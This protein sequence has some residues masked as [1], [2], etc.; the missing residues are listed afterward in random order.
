M[1]VHVLSCFS[2]C[3]T[4]CD[5]MDCSPLG[6]S[7][8]DP[9]TT[10]QETGVGC[11]FDLQGI[12]PTHEPNPGIKPMSLASPAWAGRFFTTS[13]T[14]EAPYTHCCRRHCC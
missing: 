3:L 11:H 12:F 1:C 9:F 10:K 14:R 8:W 7:P 4:L 13:A 5:P 6:S 2:S